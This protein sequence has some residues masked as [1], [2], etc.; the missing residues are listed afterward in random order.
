MSWLRTSL[1]KA[2]PRES[3]LVPSSGV[4]SL[5]A[6]LGLGLQLLMSRRNTWRT[7]GGSVTGPSS[8]SVGQ[9]FA[10]L[11]IV[12]LHMFIHCVDCICCVCCWRAQLLRLLST[13]HPYSPLPT[14]CK[15]PREATVLL[16]MS[17]PQFDD[18]CQ[19]QQLSIFVVFWGESALSTVSL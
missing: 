6:S 16:W 1:L 17:Q 13:P 19:F 3:H 7:R 15:H 4:L 12:R 2:V 5:L 9:E 11:F 10:F 14:V 8:D 18:V